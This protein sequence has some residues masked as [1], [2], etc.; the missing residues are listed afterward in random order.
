[1]SLMVRRPTGPDQ[2]TRRG[3]RWL[4]RK[5]QQL[6]WGQ[7]E[8]WRL[9]SR[10]LGLGGHCIGGCSGPHASKADRAA[11]S[12]CR[13]HRTPWR[14]RGHSP[15]GWGTLQMQCCIRAWRGPFLG[16]GLWQV[17]SPPPPQLLRTRP[18]TS[19]GRVHR[20]AFRGEDTWTCE[21]LATSGVRARVLEIRCQVPPQPAALTVQA[22]E[23]G[24][25][26]GTKVESPVS[27]TLL[28]N[29]QTSAPT[30]WRAG[31]GHSPA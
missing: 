24:H 22:W 13:A 30:Q 12:Q 8:Q 31:P 26:R 16:L 2:G 28:R 19:H 14:Q 1:M 25:R 9:P 5:G 29:P 18:R 20:E 23:Q 27:L 21:D 15:G 11:G 17:T 3:M 7:V 4:C 10:P 6:K